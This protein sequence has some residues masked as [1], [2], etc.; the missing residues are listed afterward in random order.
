MAGERVELKRFNVQ[1]G[2]GVHLLRT[3]RIPV[4]LL[5]GRRI[6]GHATPGAELGIEEVIQDP[7]RQEGAGA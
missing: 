7:G 1:D 5:S 3:A 2:V 6:G 4:A